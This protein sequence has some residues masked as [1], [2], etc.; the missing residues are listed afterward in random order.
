MIK[1]LHP[2]LLNLRWHCSWAVNVYIVY[3]GVWSMVSTYVYVRD[4]MCAQWY[5]VCCRA[6]WWIVPRAVL[7]RPCTYGVMPL[8][9]RFP[10]LLWLTRRDRLCSCL[11]PSKEIMPSFYLTSRCPYVRLCQYK[12]ADLAAADDLS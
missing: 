12:A 3:L 6:L 4:F 8:A 10:L 5:M 2:C 7:T 11:T 9:L 1:Y